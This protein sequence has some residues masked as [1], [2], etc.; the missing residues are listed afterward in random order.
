MP[1][2]NDELV[3]TFVEEATEVLAD[4]E[5][6]FLMI[7]ENGADIDSDLVNRV[8]RGIHSMKGSAGFLGL[9]AIGTLAHEAENV[10]NLI[11]NRD[12]VPRPNVVNALLRSADALRDASSAATSTSWSTRV[13]AAIP[14]AGTT[15]ARHRTRRPTV[16]DTARVTAR[17]SSTRSPAG[18]DSW[19]GRA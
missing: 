10:L 9:T 12:L 11:R 16:R 1:N 7:E 19:D 8:F 4:V 6:D 3:A 14:E 18:R 2:E 13:S 15:R 5:N 17:R